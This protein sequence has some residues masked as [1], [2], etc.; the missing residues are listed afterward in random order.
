M[1]KKRIDLSLLQ[2]IEPIIQKHRSLVVPLLNE[3]LLVYLK[4]KDQ[5]SGF[6]FKIKAHLTSGKYKVEYKPYSKN[7][8]SIFQSEL[9]RDNTIAQLK[10]WLEILDE[11]E[12]TPSVFDDPIIK[13]YQIEFQ[14]EFTSTDEDAD[15]ASFDLDK[16]LFL[17][18]YLEM[19]TLKLENSITESNKPEIIDIIEETTSLR[20]EQTSLSKNEVLKR[21]SKI[22][23]KA[24]KQGLNI[25]KE[26]FIESRKE[27]IKQ[28]IKGYIEF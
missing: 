2:A 20:S 24:R 25:L 13:K 27:L 22:W 28:L 4:D 26:I 23:A 14:A 5:E 3:D 7:Y 17:D 16:Q 9:P 12:K 6:F 8:T 18:E 1:S 19:V 21:I 10:G 15:Y 11:Y